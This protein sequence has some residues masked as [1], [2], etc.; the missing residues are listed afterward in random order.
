M[1]M[2][3]CPRRVLAVRGL[4]LLKE[5]SVQGR[6]LIT[7]DCDTKGAVWLCFY[8]P[9]ELWPSGGYYS[10]KHAIQLM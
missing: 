4:F 9:A 5:T 1:V 6:W 10:S 7:P 8:E 3:L 2:F